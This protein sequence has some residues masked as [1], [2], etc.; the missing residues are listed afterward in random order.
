MLTYADVT[1]ADV[2]SQGDTRED[3]LALPPPPLAGT[4]ACQE[5]GYAYVSIRQHTSACFSIRQHTSVDSLEYVEQ[6]HVR[7]EGTHICVEE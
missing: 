4:G 7:K 1:Y 2:C 6:E 5:G 3:L